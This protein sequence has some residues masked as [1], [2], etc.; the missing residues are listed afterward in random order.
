[1]NLTLVVWKKDVIAGYTKNDAVLALTTRL[2]PCELLM[3]VVILQ[4]LVE[5]WVL[6]L[7]SAYEITCELVIY[8]TQ[9]LYKTHQIRY[10]KHA[11]DAAAGA[12]QF[13]HKNLLQK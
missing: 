4:W 10:Y 13:S 8:I 9:L 6:A 2:G 12:M 1:M 11:M 7:L 5:L 3:L